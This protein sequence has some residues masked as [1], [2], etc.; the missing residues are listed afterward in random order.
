MKKII[1]VISLLLF[2]C[3][4]DNLTEY[5]KIM[6]E[7]DYIIV[8]VRS[9]SEYRQGHIVDSINI[10]Y[11]DISKSD[12]DKN[13]YIFVYCRSGNRSE[14]AYHTLKSL[15]YKVYDLG[16]YDNIKLPKE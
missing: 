10:P 5:E 15:G 13:K 12:L 4:C 16:A 11:S 3:G 9:E 7:N 14:V 2:L 8:D 1:V 6:K